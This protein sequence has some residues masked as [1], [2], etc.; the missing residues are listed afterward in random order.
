MVYGGKSSAKTVTISQIFSILGFTKNFSSIAYRKEQSTIKT[1]LKNAFKKAVSS[2]RFENAYEVMDFSLRSA[3]G[4]EIVFKGLDV[5]GKIKGIEGYKFLLF[6]ELDHFTQ[7]EWNMANL[8]LRGMEG[9][10]LFATWNPVRDDIWIKEEL[11]SYKWESLPLEIPGNPL[12]KLDDHSFVKLSNDG[13]ILLIRTTYFDNKWRVG[14]SDGDVEFGYRDENL[15][16]EYELLGRVNQNWYLVNVMGEWG[17]PE[18]KK[19]FAYNFSKEKHVKEG[20]LEKL[21]PLRFI[22]DFNVDPMANLCMISWFDKDGHHIWFIDETAL[23]NSGTEEM[24][25]VLKTKYTQQQHANALWTGDA[26]SRKRTA[27]QTIKGTQHLTSWVKIDKAFNLGK[28]LHTPKANP[29][30]DSTRELLNTMLALHPDIRFFPHLKYTINEMQYT[31]ATGTGD[32]IK[33]DR[34]DEGKRADFL[35][36]VRYSLWTWFN[37]FET[38]MK[39]YGVK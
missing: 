11:D 2:V 7:E 34:K 36:C 37:D 25:K 8:S 18:V 38:N 16:H 28:R 12:S 30:V 1:T 22:Q 13:K 15:I 19:P 33:D 26:T 21:P 9:Q 14:G 35:D 31:E 4:Q 32:I 24:I 29:A 23:W 5:E 3:K 6:D 10:K 20:L 17:K 39:K 27:E